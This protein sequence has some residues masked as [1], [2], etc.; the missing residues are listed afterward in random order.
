MYVGEG[1]YGSN[2]FYL[3]LLGFTIFSYIVMVFKLFLCLKITENSK[4]PG[5]HLPEFDK[6]TVY[7]EIAV[8]LSKLIDL[9]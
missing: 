1:Y 2:V 4:I 6:K 8:E 5:K 7:S 3:L 9:S